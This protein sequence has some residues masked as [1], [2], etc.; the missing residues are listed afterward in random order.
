MNFGFWDIEKWKNRTKV[1][2][3]RRS[4]GGGKRARRSC[5]GLDAQV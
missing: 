2:I 1:G 3:R 5:G 4:K